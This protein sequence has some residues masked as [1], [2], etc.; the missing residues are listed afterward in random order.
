M[1]YMQFVDKAR[2][3]PIGFVNSTPN[4]KIMELLHIANEFYRN[5]VK[6]YYQTM[7]MI[8]FTI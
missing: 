7:N 8:L 6:L 1:E 2:E 3:D 4:D 5:L